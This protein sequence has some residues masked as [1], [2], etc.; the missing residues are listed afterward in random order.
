MPGNPNPEPATMPHPHPLRRPPFFSLS[1]FGALLA[2]VLAPA[3]AR[4]QRGQELSEEQRLVQA[5]HTIQSQVL[6]GWVDTLASPRFG[7]RL[8]GTPTFNAAAD[9]VIAHLRAW[10]VAPGA[11]DGTYRQAFPNPYTLI[12]PDCGVWLDLPMPGGGVIRKPYV[13]QEDY[14]PGSTSASGE[15]TAEVVY[16]GYGITAPELGFD[17]YQGVD[18]K[19]KIVLMEPES[20]VG[21]DPDAEQF[22]RWRPYSF[23]QYKLENAA[24]HGAAGM[25]YDYH[26]VN[27][28]NAYIE[29]FV[30]SAVNTT[31]VE[32]LFAG[33]GRV[34]REVVRS[35]RDGLKPASFATGKTVTIRNTTEHHPEGVAY[36]V[37][38][39]L[40]GSDPALK[41]EVIILGGHLD[42]LGYN[43]DLMPGAN[44]NASA[45]AVIMGT[46]EALAA[47]PV[48]PRR[49]VLFL[50]FG[51][52]EQGVAGS[53]WYLD[54]PV[55]PL[56][57]TVGLLNLDMVGSGDRISGGGGG[58]YPAFWKYIEGA[59]ERWVHRIM[60]GSFNANLGR[61]RLDAARFMWAGVPS[62]S[63]A[64][65]GSRSFYHNTRDDISTITPE[66]MEDLAQILFLAVVE[67]GRADRL[68]FRP[69]G[70]PTGC[71][72]P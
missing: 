41:D 19:G 23:H 66:I 43:Y 25:L 62:I 31:V 46:A 15:V 40:E 48:R 71:G 45:V 52:E 39:L 9:W 57:K 44:D 33:T 8:T 55:F 7:G 27:P 42:G 69:A 59:N 47:S 10:G 67:M 38:G 61:P 53:A 56:A 49:S 72:R 4:A 58:N 30:Y 60:R 28:N 36:N 24:R 37:I 6:Y 64:T 20:P 18:V 3:A 13:F 5:M 11:G 29:G 17:E 22:A 65:S 35:I 34:H 21:P 16:V 54:H 50:F 14:F 51:A 63:F 12:K 70:R 26:I 32:D 68:D 2:L 1:L